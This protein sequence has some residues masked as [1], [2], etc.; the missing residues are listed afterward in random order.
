MFFNINLTISILYFTFTLKTKYIS[1]MVVGKA[2]LSFPIASSVTFPFAIDNP[3]RL[4]FSSSDSK[5]FA[6]LKISVVPFSLSEIFSSLSMAGSFFTIKSQLKWCPLKE[7]LQQAYLNR[8]LLVTFTSTCLFDS[9]TLVSRKLHSL[10]IWYLFIDASAHS[11]LFKWHKMLH[12]GK[13]YACFVNH[14]IHNQSSGHC[15][16][17][18]ENT[19]IYTYIHMCIYI[20]PHTHIHI[21]TYTHEFFFFRLVHNSSIL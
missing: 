1:L 7:A 2:L 16:L 9:I 20:Y 6:Q 21:Y 17:L 11:L 15:I 19:C 14:C 12:E 5:A 10:L 8:F 18:G 4:H 3:A 13:G